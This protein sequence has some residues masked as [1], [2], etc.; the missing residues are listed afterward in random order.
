MCDNA[1]DMVGSEAIKE[2]FHYLERHDLL[3]CD[4]VVSGLYDDEAGVE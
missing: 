2:L 4:A 1:V 3:D